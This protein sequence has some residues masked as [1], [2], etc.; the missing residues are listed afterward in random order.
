[1]SSYKCCSTR[2]HK[3]YCI[4]S[5]ECV[6][7]NY[8]Y[9][10]DLSEVKDWDGTPPR[11]FKIH[12]RMAYMTVYE[13]I[14]EHARAL[15]KKQDPNANI[16]KVVLGELQ[17]SQKLP[18]DT[19][20]YNTIRKI[21]SNNEE[22]LKYVPKQELVDENAFLRILLPAELTKIQIEEI[23]SCVVIDIVNAKSEGQAIG[24]SMKL[25]KE[26]ADGKIIPSAIVQ[27]VIKRVRTK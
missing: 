21:I 8:Q 4:L 6:N 23:L 2:A 10:I 7:E 19:T 11:I 17:R 20:C 24:L 12:R 22:T 14:Q 13:G 1:M 26:K 27:D 16:L 18:D 9:H 25:L 3:E 15:V 5:T